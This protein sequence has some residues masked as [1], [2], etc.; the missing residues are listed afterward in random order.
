MKFYETMRTVMMCGFCIYIGV[1][2]VAV[3]KV[4]PL[5]GLTMVIVGFLVL[6]LWHLYDISN[7]LE[8]LEEKI[9]MTQSSPNMTET[10][11]L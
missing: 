8:T 9:T 4:P 2:L 1:L 6:I 5:E 3:W 7:T 11:D 10:K